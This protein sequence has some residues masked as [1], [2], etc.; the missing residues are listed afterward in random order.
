[1]AAHASARLR[2]GDGFALR[3]VE[4]VPVLVDEGHVGRVPALGCF[5]C[6]EAV[7]SGSGP[8]LTRVQDLASLK[9]CRRNLGLVVGEVGAEPSVGLLDCALVLDIFA[10]V[11]VG[12]L[13][14]NLAFFV[15]LGYF[16]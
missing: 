15:A 5:L 11:G 2:V 3:S 7:W 13:P 10:A 1:M 16:G 6:V 9:L 14:R 8:V 4:V 12:E